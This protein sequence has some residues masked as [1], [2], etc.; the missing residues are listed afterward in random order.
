MKEG[1]GAVMRHWKHAIAALAF[2]GALATHACITTKELPK[3]KPETELESLLND[4]ARPV[5]NAY[6]PATG[7]NNTS[8]FHGYFCHC[9]VRDLR[10]IE[11]VRAVIKGESSEVIVRTYTIQG[12]H[13]EIECRFARHT[14]PLGVL[15][16][17][18]T[19]DN[20]FREG[21]LKLLEVWYIRRPEPEHHPRHLYILEVNDARSLQQQVD[22][23][24]R[25]T[26]H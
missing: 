26:P 14:T 23:F 17:L 19:G 15:E 25:I 5:L 16:C 11:K 1:T 8:Y 22:E 20:G 12:T 3:K 2:T 9:A 18:T 7:T 24:R 10:L 4:L 13:D 21:D 6:P